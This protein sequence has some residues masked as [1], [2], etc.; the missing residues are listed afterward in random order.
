M[1]VLPVLVAFPRE[2]SVDSSR[3]MLWDTLDFYMPALLHTLENALMAASALLL[4]CALMYCL[5]SVA[6]LPLHIALRSDGF[7]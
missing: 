1:P 4:Q 6:L 7:D 5:T 2:V 3:K